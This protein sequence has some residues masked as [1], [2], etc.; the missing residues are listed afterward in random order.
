M[1]YIKWSSYFIFIILLYFNILEQCNMEV[2]SP[3][4]CESDDME[5][6]IR[7][8]SDVYKF[9]KSN[10]DLNKRLTELEGEIKRLN[11]KLE[12]QEEHINGEIV[13]QRRMDGSENF[14][15]VW[16]DYKHGFGNQ[17]REFF[18]GLQRLHK[19]T[20]SRRFELWVVMEDFDDVRRYAK[21]DN[22]V[23]ASEKENYKL[24]SLGQYEGTAGDSLT[25]HLGYSFTTKDRDNDVDQGN[26]C[27]QLYVGAW[28]YKSCH[29][30]NLNGEY[31]R[32]STTL[33]GRGVI[34]NAFRALYYSLKF[35][36]LSIRPKLF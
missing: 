9:V 22:F 4:F 17:S 21:Y 14:Y 3:K 13:I 2:I 23:V 29:A 28:W 15:R 27:A 7:W 34:W 5:G 8:Y 18:I 32:G 25:Y 6:L 33:Y 26:N 11:R 36:E 24:Q 16:E 20:N 1:N 19:L 31:L 12:H 10:E 35:V 30:C